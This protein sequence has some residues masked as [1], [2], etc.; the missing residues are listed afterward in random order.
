MIMHLLILCIIGMFFDADAAA[1]TYSMGVDMADSVPNSFWGCIYGQ[2]YRFAVIRVYRNANGGTP[3]TYAPT[4]ILNALNANLTVYIYHF[5]N[6]QKDG[7]LQ[8]REM[9]DYLR[10]HGIGTFRFVFLDVEWVDIGTDWSHTNHA[11]N[12]Q[13]IQSFVT[14]A[15]NNGVDVGIY[16]KSVH[17]PDITGN[18]EP[19]RALSS[20]IWYWYIRNDGTFSADYDSFVNFGGWTKS[21]VGMKQWLQ[22][23]PF[24]SQSQVDRNIILNSGKLVPSFSP[25]N[26]H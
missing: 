20:V 14:E 9:R 21:D 2:G 10:Q 17:W 16:S 8:F 15:N 25:G 26:K 23:K 4:N 1:A 11:A 13:V 24:C 18:W 6:A 12:R 19:G 7:G 3:D 22:D 5:P